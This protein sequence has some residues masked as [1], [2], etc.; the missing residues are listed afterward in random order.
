MKKEIITGIIF[1]LIFAL[2]L[3]NT[4]I[5]EKLTSELLDLI[6]QSRS[7]AE[8]GDWENAINKALE[9][10]QRWNKADPYTHI[11]VRHSEIDSTTDAFYELLKALY[12]EEIGNAKGAYM[13]VT[14]HLVSIQ[15]MDKV[16][17][18]SIF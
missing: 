18:G 10:E 11:V 17:L 7:Y 6:E 13:A 8:K 4:H 15:G 16:T 1:L 2:T 12:S 14:A 3:V 9:A 5:L